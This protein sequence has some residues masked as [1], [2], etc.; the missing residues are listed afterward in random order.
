MN[1]IMQKGFSPVIF[2][3]AA[4]TILLVSTVVTFLISKMS[5]Q[6]QPTFQDSAPKSTPPETFNIHTTPKV[7]AYKN[8]HISLEQVKVFG[9]YLVPRNINLSKS[10]EFQ[11][12]NWRK[13]ME[14]VLK[15]ATTFWSRELENK[16]NF[17][18]EIL[19]KPLEGSLDL[20]IYDF[21]STK[22]EVVKMLEDEKNQNFRADIRETKNKG[23]FVIYSIYIA[24]DRECDEYKQLGYKDYGECG[25]AEGKFYSDSSRGS[26][27]FL[28]S[29]D[30]FYSEADEALAVHG[31]ITTAHEFGHAL[32]IPHPFDDQ[33]LSQQNQNY[34]KDP[35]NLMG[36]GFCKLE[37]CFLMPEQK[38]KMGL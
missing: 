5:A 4:S 19:E 34:G 29:T 25:K 31:P 21:N 26:L 37:N 17:S 10:K 15:R 3:V 20:S 1:I 8:P 2:L 27:G 28:V 14:K 22:N 33:E 23:F 35:G 32:G 30:V 11:T 9:V 38:K 7:Y 24:T 6:P 12:R 13:D 36:H 18:V 16:A